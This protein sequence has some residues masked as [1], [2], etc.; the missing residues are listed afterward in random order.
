MIGTH[1]IIEN[2]LFDIASRLKEIDPA[3][4]IAREH[5]HGRFE[6][7]V[8]GQRGG[9]LALALPFERLDERTLRFARKTRAER[10]ADLIKEAEEHNLRL[11]REEMQRAIH[12]MSERGC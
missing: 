2:D 5:K 9:T 3:Y 12:R 7:H 4:F 6:L 11:E 1:Q 10:A 8:K